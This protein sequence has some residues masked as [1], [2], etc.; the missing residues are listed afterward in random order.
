[1]IKENLIFHL[2]HNK[3]VA[4]KINDNNTTHLISTKMLNEEIEMLCN[5]KTLLHALKINNIPQKRVVYIFKANVDNQ[6]YDNHK[7]S[8]VKIN[9]NL[10]DLQSNEENIEYLDKYT[11]NNSN[12]N[13]YKTCQDFFSVGIINNRTIEGFSIGT[14]ASSKYTK[15]FTIDKG[16]EQNNWNSY[17]IYEDTYQDYNDIED[18]NMAKS[19]VLKG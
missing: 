2:T 16:E 3:E 5:N 14:Y 12:L 19:Y 15:E 10:A 9:V 6:E 1:M 8:S 7:V 11:D 13:V 17:V 18:N 4:N